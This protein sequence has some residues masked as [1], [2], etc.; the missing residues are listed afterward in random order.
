MLQLGDKLDLKGWV[1]SC[2][3]SG[4]GIRRWQVKLLGRRTDWIAGPYSLS[5]ACV[6]TAGIYYPVTE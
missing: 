5:W 4:T 2:A 3:G 6:P 1:L